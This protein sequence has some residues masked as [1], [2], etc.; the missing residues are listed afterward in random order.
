VI[1][2]KKRISIIFIV[3]L[4]FYTI[5]GFESKEQIKLLG[6]K[7]FELESKGEQLDFK[8]TE[9]KQA[10]IQLMEEKAEL[11]KINEKLNSEL[12]VLKTEKGK[13]I[14][15]TE[16]LEKQNADLKKQL[17][18]NTTSTANNNSF[19]VA[20]LT[21]D[22]GP[23]DNTPKIL[24]IL[25]ENNIK[26]TFFVNGYPARR[27]IYQRIINEGHTI[28][29]HTYSH[30]YAYLYQTVDGFNSDKQKLDD[31]IYEITNVKPQILR[32]P[33]GSNN[34]VSYRYGG[35]AFMDTLTKQVKQ[36]G[37]KYFDWNV[38]ST[39]ASVVTQDKDKIISQ[40]LNG[41]KNKKQAIIL[42]HDSQPKTTTA[43]ALPSIISGLKEQG[44]IFSSLSPETAPIQF[45]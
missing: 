39:D 2:Y 18:A 23:S 26:A 12:E 25:K 37:V 21:F 28:G 31:F 16:V 22:D 32:F 33:G 4:T 38:D 9:L 11:I 29:N 24:D 17:S 35:T 44:F 43:Q 40:V 1:T 27:E 30:N 6:N 45:K 34:Q 20:Y 14:E 36:A 42:M 15:N 5:A 19:K 41:S 8:I 13:L 3:L 10:N 7:T